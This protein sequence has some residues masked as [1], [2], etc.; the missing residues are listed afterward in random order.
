MRRSL[1]KVKRLWIGPV[2]SQ[3]TCDLHQLSQLRD[4][5]KEKPQPG[6]RGGAWGL[7]LLIFERTT[8]PVTIR[9]MIEG[10]TRFL[11]RPIKG[12]LLDS[13]V[14]QFD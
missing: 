13:I 8:H 4:G 5:A 6:A 7:G 10:L 1:N 12:R 11:S 14:C 9:T 2:T 3:A